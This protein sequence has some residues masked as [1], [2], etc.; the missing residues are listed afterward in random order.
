MFQDFEPEK[1][2]IVCRTLRLEIFNIE[3]RDNLP[4]NFYEVT[5]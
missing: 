2:K 5:L 1:K 3:R 4:L